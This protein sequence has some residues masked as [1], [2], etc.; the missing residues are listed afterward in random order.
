MRG[1]RQ[2]AVLVYVRFF[3]AQALAFLFNPVIAAWTM[4]QAIGGLYASIAILRKGPSAQEVSVVHFPLRGTWRVVRGGVTRKHSHSWGVPAQR[5]AYDFVS[6]PSPA[7]PGPL[8]RYPAFGQPILAAEEG[9]VASCCD[10]YR[11]YPR[12]GTGWIDWR[13][14]DPRGNHVV[15]RHGDGRYSLYAHLRRGSVR[16]QK[17]QRVQV[18]DELGACG[19]SGHST[20]PHLHFHVQR[21]YSVFAGIGVPAAFVDV[22]LD[23]DEPGAAFLRPD[24]VVRSSARGS[25]DARAP[26]LPRPRGLVADAVGSVIALALTMLGVYGLLRAVV[27]L[28]RR[29]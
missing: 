27:G 1:A 14:R 9:Y 25:L 2:A 29:C 11:D 24:Q 10:R 17:G 18:A 26:T 22:E 28:I 8:A 19:N 20:E 23:G 12:P 3:A 16:V 13:V 5:Y 15:V 21:G 4:L 6:E 7:G